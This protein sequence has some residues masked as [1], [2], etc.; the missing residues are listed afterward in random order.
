[1]ERSGRVE[2]P[3]ALR[4][5]RGRWA[6]IATFVSVVS[7]AFA[8]TKMQV[9]ATEEYA[10]IAKENRLRP[11]VVP[12]PRG[13]IYDRYG[14]VVADN[15]VGYQV[16][17]MPAPIDSLQ[18]ALERL[19]PVLGLTDADVERAFRKYRREPHLPMV[20]KQDAAPGA[21]ARLLERRFLFPGVLIHEYPK[22]RYP[23]GDAVAHVIGYV[24]EIS[25]AE[26][27]LP[28]FEGYRQ[29]RWIGKAG[30]E[31][32][33][34]RELGGEPGMRY[35]EVDAVGRIKRWLPEET[36]V[37][38]IPGRD[39][40]LHLDL[41]LQRY[42]AE[43][44]RDFARTNGFSDLR[45]AFV[46]IEPAT[47]G[48][49]ALYATPNFDPNAFVGGIDPAVW[50][51]LNEDPADP[52]LNRASGS[53]QPPG[54]TFKLATAAMAMSL[55]LLKP[56]DRMPVPCGGGLRYERRYAK[57]WYGRGHGSLDLIGAIK[58]SCNVYFYQVGIRI[59]LERFMREGARLGFGRP[60]GIDLPNE[61]TSTFPEGKRWWE[62]HFGYR[63]Y[64]NEVMSLSIGQG[65]VTLTPL[66]LTQLYVALARRDGKAP[67]PRLAV[68]DSA[69]P[70]SLDLG[71][72]EE[73][74]MALRRGFRRVVGPGGTAA[75]SRLPGWDFM[76]K[77]GTAQNP[78]GPDHAW[79]VGVGG[80]FG[81]EPE[82]VA[83]MLLENGEHGYV[84]SG[85]V[86]NAVNFF[87]T[88][89]HGLPFERYPTPRE[90]LPRGLDVDWRWYL[91]DVVDPPVTEP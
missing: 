25:E 83:T 38:P 55:G 68:T 50:Q 26:L 30:L 1:M 8:L 10:L 84:A 43:L 35:L 56:T 12:A 87:L 34:E 72:N 46:A 88:R 11:I 3:R 20:V 22:R 42:V 90:R 58:N 89:R 32:S 71:L 5:W 13:T 36:G 37:P 15:V 65:A 23:A 86:A 73:Q 21:V 80:P 57:C 66:K 9:F 39:I 17:L 44:F 2:H 63:P 14:R 81:E 70:I 51:G 76:G 45:A 62:E 53:S 16:L 24:N 6:R 79:F 60:T 75:L 18:A 48:V 54:S 19:R 61:L 82:I 47:G 59:G 74:I 7:L 78:H 28:E 33:Y 49:L 31:R 77:T 52:L 41:D 27:A 85:V 4:R 64:D 67:A 91:S 40:R 29:G 69:P